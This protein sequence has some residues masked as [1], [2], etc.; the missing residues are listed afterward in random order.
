MSDSAT[1]RGR[2]RR[3]LW[4]TVFLVLA[5]VVALLFVV[6][7]IVGDHG[8]GRHSSSDGVVVLSS[9]VFR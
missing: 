5:V 9:A 2:A 4:V 1:E 7:L 3:P 6:L 8:P